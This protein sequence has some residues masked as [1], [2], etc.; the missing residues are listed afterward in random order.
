MVFV[1]LIA[2]TFAILTGLAQL[3]RPKG[4]AR[5]RR[6]GHVWT[7]A[8]TVACLSSFGIPGTPRLIFGLGPL[9]VLSA[10]T[11]ACLAISITAARRGRMALHRNFAIGA[12]TGL[13][14]A[15]MAALAMP[16]R[17]LH[18]WLIG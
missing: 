6:T 2:A 1:H 17:L 16:G 12:F 15:G 10:W 5:H 14:I 8:M 3:L 11:L 13:F 7:L 9:H 4:T 18:G